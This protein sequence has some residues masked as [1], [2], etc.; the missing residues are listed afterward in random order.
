MHDMPTGFYL[1]QPSFSEPT[2]VRPSPMAG[3][4]APSG[5]MMGVLGNPPLVNKVDL[6]AAR[7][8]Q[9]A[10]IDEL[11]KFKEQVASMIKN[12]FDIDMGNSRLYQKPYKAEFDLMAYPFGWRVPDFIKFGGEDNHT[13][14][15]HISQYIAQLGEV[16][17]HESFKV[18]LVSLSLTGTAFAWFSSLAPNSIDSWNQIE[19]KFHD[20]FFSGDYQ[21]KL[22]D[23]ASVKQGKDETVSNYLKRFKEVKNRCF[24]LSISDSDLAN[25]AAKS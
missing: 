4:T 9:L 23:L 25:L 20:H 15:E 22:I 6:S 1:G 14:W 5:Q 10:A 8:S 2:L 17:A 16:S 11:N 19:Q 13:T 3:L 21:L 7:Q 18:R 24:N 12:K